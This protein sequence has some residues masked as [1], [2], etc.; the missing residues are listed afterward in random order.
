MD[1]G[2]RTLETGT[3]CDH[4]QSSGDVHNWCGSTQISGDTEHPESVHQV[5]SESEIV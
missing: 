5:D 1:T 3:C 4:H 2:H